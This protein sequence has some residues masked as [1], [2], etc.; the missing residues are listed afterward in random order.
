MVLPNTEPKLQSYNLGYVHTYVF[1]VMLKMLSIFSVDT[2]GLIP[3]WRRRYMSMHFHLLIWIHF[4]EHS[5]I[6]VVSP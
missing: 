1:L 4:R 6:D 3:F 5:H 2:T